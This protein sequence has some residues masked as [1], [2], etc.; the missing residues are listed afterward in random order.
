MKKQLSNWSKNIKKAMIDKDMDTTDVA[1]RMKW[2]RQYASSI[3][4][5][6]VYQRESVNRLSTF[7]GLDNPSEN[8][9]LAKSRKESHE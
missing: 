1:E 2:T 6:R 7:F 5:G 4:N 9:T 8:S 3:I